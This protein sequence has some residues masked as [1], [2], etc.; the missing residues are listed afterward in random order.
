MDNVFDFFITASLGLSMHRDGH[1]FATRSL[2]LSNRLS[3]REVRSKRLRAQMVQLVHTVHEVGN[4]LHVLTQSKLASEWR[5]LNLVGLSHFLNLIN[6]TKILI[7]TEAARQAGEI[8]VCCDRYESRAS[9]LKSKPL[10][11]S[12]SD[13]TD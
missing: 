9:F 4:L 11:S 2:G 8:C 5:L 12:K 7:A 10:R 6:Q 3:L 13:F 1:G